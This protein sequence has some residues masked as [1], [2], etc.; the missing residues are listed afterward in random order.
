MNLEIT[1]KVVQ[2]GQ[3]QTGEGRN[4]PWVKQELIIESEDQYPRKVCLMC[5]GERSDEAKTF[6]P[7]EKIKAGINIES[8]EYNGR[9][10]TDV[11][12]WK[13]EKVSSAPVASAL[14]EPPYPEDFTENQSMEDDLPF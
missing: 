14:N 10:F 9:W 3:R 11:K 12:V 1:G 5:W 2:L 13:F 8:R 6:V 4:G 7:G